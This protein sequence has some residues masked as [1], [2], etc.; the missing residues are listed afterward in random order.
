MKN[1]FF[2]LQVI[3]RVP[4]SYPLRPVEVDGVRAGVS[5]AVW[6]K[7]LL[8]MHTLLLTQVKKKKFRG[9]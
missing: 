9:L 4:P 7:W 5:E 8:S 6:R 3:I 1:F 2:F